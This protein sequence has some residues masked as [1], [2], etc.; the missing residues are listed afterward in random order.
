MDLKPQQIMLTKP[1]DLFYEVFTFSF[2]KNVLEYVKLGMEMK[3]SLE[4]DQELLKQ[5]MDWNL[6]MAI[7]YRS[8]RKKIIRSQLHL[9][10]KVLHDL[11]SVIR[12]IGEAGS[13]M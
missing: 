2:Y 7:V 3:S 10:E 6:R 1:R 12:Y 8:E 9:I 11:E 13:A 4:K 5:D